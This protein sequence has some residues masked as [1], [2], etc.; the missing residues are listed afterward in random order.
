M[1]TEIPTRNSAKS[2]SMK[3]YHSRTLAGEEGTAGALWADE[4]TENELRPPKG[5]LVRTGGDFR[6]PAARRAGS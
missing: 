4:S 3:K 2:S 6:G 1:I 5:A